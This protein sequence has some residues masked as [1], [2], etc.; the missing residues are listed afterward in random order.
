MGT[1]SQD[2][3]KPL[4]LT[5]THTHTHTHTTYTVTHMHAS[6]HAH[7]HARMHTCTHT[8]HTH[9]HIRVSYGGGG[10][11]IP[12]PPT[13]PQFPPPRNLEIEY[14]YYISCHQ[15]VWKFCPR[16]HQKQSERYINSKFSWGG[17][18][19][20]PPSR[21]TCVS[22]AT[23]TLLPSCSPPHLIILYETL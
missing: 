17:M 3:G 18:P 15:N 19:P 14:G 22:H 2:Y 9:M 13:Q 5:H 7:T 20:D 6:T 8:T 23:I 4:S 11:G 16:L 10:A 1:P 12:P 21:H